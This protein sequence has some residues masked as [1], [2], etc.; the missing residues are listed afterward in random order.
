MAQDC[1]C[2]SGL[3]NLK[4]SD[5]VVTPG[6]LRKM[7]FVKYLKAE[8]TINGI[9]L[10]QPFGEADIDALINESDKNLRWFLT[11][12]VSEITTDRADPNFQTVDNQ[13]KFISQGTRTVTGKFFGTSAEFSKKLDGNRCVDLGYFMVDSS[14]GLSGIH[15]RDLFLDPIQ[16]DKETF[17][18][19]INFPTEGNIFD[20]MFS[21][22]W[23]RLVCDGDIRTLGFSDHGTNLLAKNGLCDVL[24]RNGAANSDT[25]IQIDLYSVD[26]SAKGEAFTGL[27]LA[28]FTVTNTTTTDAITATAVGEEPDGTYTLTIPAQTAGD[29]ITVTAAKTGFDFSATVNEVITAV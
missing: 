23:D 6:I 10:S 5:C 11:S 29:K 13:N 3:Y 7:I 19:K 1:N 28:D 8:G 26:G 24:A 25:E 16:I 21:F 20:V 9:D 15:N 18:S 2:D 12:K 27:L 22:E 4:P 14:S 17:W